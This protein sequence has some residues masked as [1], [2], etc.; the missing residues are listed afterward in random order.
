MDTN[1]INIIREFFT[2]QPVVYVW[3]FGSYS[4]DEQTADSDIDLL[5]QFDKDAHVGLF[6]HTRMILQL[7]KLLGRKVDLV[8]EDALMKF[9]QSSVSHDKKLIY[10]RA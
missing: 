8:P 5:V 9:A 7:E 3:L 4:R 6:A 1:D 2:E 10:S